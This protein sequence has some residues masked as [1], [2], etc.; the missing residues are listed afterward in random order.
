[1]YEDKINSLPEHISKKIEPC[2][3]TGCWNF[4]GKDPSSNGYQRAWYK[5]VR[6]MAH[7]IVYT[8]IVGGNIEGKQLDHSC[9]NRSCVNPKHLEPM[10]GKK[11][12]ILREKRKK[13]RLKVK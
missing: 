10:S 12:C 5:G 6:S 9:C 13:Q 2:R 11:N 1:M 3:D 8:L 4:I 7:R